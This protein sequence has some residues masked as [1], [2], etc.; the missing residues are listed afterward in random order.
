MQGYTVSRVQS[1][2]ANDPRR[3][4][5]SYTYFIEAEP[6]AC[7]LSKDI[8]WGL[9]TMSKD[10]A[11]GFAFGVFAIVCAPKFSKIST[12]SLSSRKS[13]IAI[14]SIPQKIFSQKLR[15]LK[16]IFSQNSPY[17]PQHFCIVSWNKS[18]KVS[19]QG[20]SPLSTLIHLLRYHSVVVLA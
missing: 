3:S 19:Y 16:I 1:H 11:T 4:E 20:F 17:F 2:K 14:D 18:L 6:R 7:I 12:P 9:T 15:P 10:F 13:T 5:D 8:A